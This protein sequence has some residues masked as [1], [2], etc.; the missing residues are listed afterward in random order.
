MNIIGITGTNGSGKGTVVEY[1]VEKYKFKHYS[2]RK[3]IEAE[4]AKKGW[5][6][7]RENLRI[8][9]N[10]IRTLNGPSYIAEQL[11]QQAIKDGQSAV[12]ESLRNPQEVI[13][14]RQKPER[15]LMLA[16]DAKVEI[17]YERILKRKSS[18]DHVRLEKFIQDEQAEMNDPDPNGLR[19]TEC[20]KLADLVIMNDHDIKTL[21]LEVDNA[22]QGLV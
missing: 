5:P 6:P 18:T 22:I 20:I 10:E 14:L 2:A 13:A 17:R 7:T 15:F 1:L 11:Y 4:V 12:I 8:T 21:Q 16:V 9:A 3:F 19:I